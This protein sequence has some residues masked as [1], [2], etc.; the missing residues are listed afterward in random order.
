V[1]AAIDGFEESGIVRAYL[2]NHASYTEYPQDLHAVQPNYFETT[3][4]KFAR[5]LWSSSDPMVKNNILFPIMGH[6]L[7]SGLSLGEILYTA[8]GS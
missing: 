7:T 5:E 3:E 4:S 2:T 8:R 1:S 6:P